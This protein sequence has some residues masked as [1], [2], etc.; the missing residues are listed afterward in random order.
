M[1]SLTFIVPLG[2]IFSSNDTNLNPLLF[3]TT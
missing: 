2:L 3:I 1:A